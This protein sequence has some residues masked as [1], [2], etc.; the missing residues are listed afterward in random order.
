MCLKIYL[1]L[2]CS[3]IYIVNFIIKNRIRDE[4]DYISCIV[5]INSIIHYINILLSIMVYTNYKVCF[6]YLSNTEYECYTKNLNL[7]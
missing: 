4:T 6:T 2:K 5:S 3:T 7:V 1:L